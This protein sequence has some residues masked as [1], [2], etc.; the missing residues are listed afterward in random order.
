MAKSKRYCLYWKTNQIT[1][2]KDFNICVVMIPDI[3]VINCIIVNKEDF[4]YAE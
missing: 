1:G 4:N 3:L 2:E